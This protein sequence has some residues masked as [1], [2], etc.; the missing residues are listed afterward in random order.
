ME[1]NMVHMY[2]LLGHNIVLDAPSGAVHEVDDETF[3]F[4]ETHDL[5][6]DIQ[7][8]LTRDEQEIWEELSQ[9]IKDGMLSSKEEEV[10]P[11]AANT[12][13]KAMCLHVAHDCN[14]R[15]RYCFAS[16]GGF[17]AERGLMTEEVAHK[18]IDYLL[19][20]CANRKNLEVDFFGG[21]P[22]M[23]MDTVKSTVEYARKRAPEKNF[24][25]TI[26]TNGI[27]LDDDSI[28]YI[29][30]EMSN[31][32]LSLDGRKEINDFLRPKIDGTGSYDTVVP[33]Y[34][35]LIQN[36]TGDHFIRGTF[37]AKNLNFLTDIEHL[38]D[39]GFQSLSMEPVVLPAGHPLALREEHVEQL[40]LEY[41]KLT[42]RM[43]ENRD[44]SFFHFQVDLEGGPCIYKRTRGCGAGFE[45]VAVTPSGE[46]YPCHQ[47]VGKEEFFM[48][49]VLEDTLDS[50]L[51]S[52][53]RNI[54]IGTR[55]Q[56][57]TCWAKYLCSGGCS[58]SNFS[59]NGSLNTPY[60]IG[61][62]LEKKRLE[63]SILLK[64]L[65]YDTYNA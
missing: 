62:S 13:L 53:F 55:T 16:T 24:R 29:N 40:E 10:P 17:G 19:K 7:P 48:G 26:T 46:V 44:F 21:E 64:V 11:I 14:L 60:A 52:E 63:C 36:R 32:V 18:A 34:H 25:F 5:S 27:E 61:C 38:V 28:D 43:I 15:C 58:A 2:R 8:N 37:T 33:R 65:E 51:S 57:P 47:F 22:L 49:S 42:Q 6:L 9:L 23:A 41:E 30:R 59:V 45:Y 12:P 4:L 20:R 39:I 1:A 54:H 35:Q 56:C 31:V 50:E 3:Q